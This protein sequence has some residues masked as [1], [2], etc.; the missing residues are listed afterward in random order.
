MVNPYDELY[1]SVDW[2]K[3]PFGIPLKHWNFVAETIKTRIKELLPPSPVSLLDV[4]GGFG[5]LHGFLSEQQKAWYVNVDFSRVLLSMSK[6]ERLQ[7]VAEALPIRD[8]CFEAVVCSEVLEHVNDKEETLR[9]IHRVLK[10]GGTLVLTTPRS[11]RNETWNK[12]KWKA[13]FL[14]TYLALALPDFIK[15]EVI[16]TKKATK[17][18]KEVKNEPTDENWLF[19]FLQQLG[20]TVVDF[21]RVFAFWKRHP[22]FPIWF[23]NLMERRYKGSKLCHTSVFKAK[24]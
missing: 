12:A 3:K 6:G 23:K 17:T 16:P 19:G 13:I 2:S 7:G 1:R 18:P 14:L 5:V 21:D 20:F 15:H 4:G 8:A 11:A 22:H 10:E 9:E 24:K